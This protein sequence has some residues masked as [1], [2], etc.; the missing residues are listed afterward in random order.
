MGLS[1]VTVCLDPPHK[2]L[3]GMINGGSMAVDVGVCGMPDP[4]GFLTLA[5]LEMARLPSHLLARRDC[6]MQPASVRQLHRQPRRL[7]GANQDEEQAM[8]HASRRQTGLEALSHGSRG[9]KF[10]STLTHV[11]WRGGKSRYMTPSQVLP[12]YQTNWQACKVLGSGSGDVDSGHSSPRARQFPS[13]LEPGTC[14][15]GPCC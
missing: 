4:V 12:R 2:K 3:H 7:Q 5:C 8:M 14:P 11:L 1:T 15:A 10:R 13:L 6:P 9:Q